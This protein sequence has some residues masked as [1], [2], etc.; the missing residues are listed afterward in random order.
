VALVDSQTG[1]QSELCCAVG[2][3]GEA[4]G[5]PVKTLR[6]CPEH[7]RQARGGRPPRLAPIAAANGGLPPEERRRLA[8]ELTA[9]GWS[10]TRTGQRLGVSRSTIELDLRDGRPRPPAGDSVPAPEPGRYEARGLAVVEA[11]RQLDRALA[12]WRQGLAELN[13]PRMASG[14]YAEYAPRCLIPRVS[15][16]TRRDRG[17]R[18]PA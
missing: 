15:R 13:A 4:N 18:L 16:P 3:D 10:Q 12:G 17:D 14:P 7:A 6:F 9:A 5:E 1:T 11:G 2:C 8:R